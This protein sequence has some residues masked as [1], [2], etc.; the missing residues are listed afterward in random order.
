M[1]NEWTGKFEDAVKVGLSGVNEVK[2]E[3]LPCWLLIPKF[4]RQDIPRQ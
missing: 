3:K 4:F 1:H 2:N